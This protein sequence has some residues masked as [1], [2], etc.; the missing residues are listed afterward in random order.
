MTS[1]SPQRL[2]SKRVSIAFAVGLLLTAINPALAQDKEEL[3]LKLTPMEP[4]KMGI[5]LNDKDLISAPMMSLPLT[6]DQV[7]DGRIKTENTDT[8]TVLVGQVRTSK[9]LGVARKANAKPLSRY[10]GPELIFINVRLKNTSAEPII[11]VG[12]Q[13]KAV[14]TGGAATPALPK[15]Y[16]VK[17]DN[18][19]MNPAKVVAIAGVSAASLG[20]AG[21]IFYEMLAPQDN[22]KRGMGDAIGRD[23]G[24][25][26]IEASRLNRRVILPQDETTGWVAFYA[27]DY[28]N[29]TNLTVPILMAPFP[30]RGGLLTIPIN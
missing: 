27:K 30:T 21:P 26:E 14:S 18:S 20:L 3:P 13:A 24:R 5:D 9:M 29:A 6:P 17:L 19:L 8:N 2:K 12:D 1:R 25:H 10:K 16:L 28:Q 11:L 7:Q 15:E 22:R 4:A 23:L